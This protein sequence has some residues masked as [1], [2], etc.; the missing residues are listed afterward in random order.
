MKW[1][2]FI[3]IDWKRSSQ[4]C[5]LGNI[6]D[7]WY[8]TSSCS[9][10]VSVGLHM[11][12]HFTI[13]NSLQLKIHQDCK[14]GGKIQYYVCTTFEELAMSPI[15]KTFF[16]ILCRSIA[17][18]VEKL[19]LYWTWNKQFNK[20]DVMLIFKKKGRSGLHREYYFRFQRKSKTWQMLPY[21]KN[22]IP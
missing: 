8:Q 13:F 10:Q 14:L 9:L 11:Q 19:V 5:C 16:L 3:P 1:I 12:S 15:G 17:Y 7:I 6:N 4:M 22:R 2:Q 20:L 21:V 18:L